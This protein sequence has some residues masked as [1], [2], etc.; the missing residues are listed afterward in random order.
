MNNVTV[1]NCNI[2]HLPKIY[3]RA[4][5]ITPVQNNVEVPFDIKRIFY[6]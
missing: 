5:S 3:N 4:G 2:I 6:L 1:F